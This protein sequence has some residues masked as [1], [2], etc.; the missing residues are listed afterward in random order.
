MTWF[1]LGLA[2]FFLITELTTAELVAIWFFGSAFI[3]T[4]VSAIF[5]Q[6]FIVWQ[7]VIFIVLSAILLIATRPFVKKLTAKN[8]NQATNLDLI[9]SHKALVTQTIQ[10]DLE[11]GAVKINGLIW[12][13]RS[14]DGENIEKGSLVTVQSI[15]GNK[16]IVK[17]I[18][19]E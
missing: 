9:I 15:Q 3:L 1:W 11:E 14:E 2:I 13:A 18:K 19:E 17:K 12:T 10:N 8:K 5:P 4:V 16:L 6:M 7:I